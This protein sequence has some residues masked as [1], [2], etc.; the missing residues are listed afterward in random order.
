ML[1]T[2]IR[3]LFGLR[4]A[5]ALLAFMS[6]LSTTS[7]QTINVLVVAERATLGKT[8]AQFEAGLRMAQGISKSL[9]SQCYFR[10]NSDNER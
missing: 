6:F 2:S 4:A 9:A 7:A 3:G 1:S 10:Q 5:L 8:V